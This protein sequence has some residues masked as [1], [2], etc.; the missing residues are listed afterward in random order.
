M[1]PDLEQKVREHEGNHLVFRAI[2][3]KYGKEGK[4]KF[5]DH[6]LSG[7]KPETVR[8]FYKKY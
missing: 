3:K 6:I 4:E 2:E 1:R 5:L 7:F 8:H